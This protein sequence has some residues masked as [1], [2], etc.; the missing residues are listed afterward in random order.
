MVEARWLSGVEAGVM[1]AKRLELL[2]FNEK[3]NNFCIFA[4]CILKLYPCVYYS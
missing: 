3:C 1:K 4:D 2:Y